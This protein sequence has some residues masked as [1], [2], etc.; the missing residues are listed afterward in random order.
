MLRFTFVVAAARY[1]YPQDGPALEQSPIHR[2]ADRGVTSAL[3]AL[4][5]PPPTPNTRITHGLTPPSGM[6][7]AVGSV[8]VR[9]VV[10]VVG[11][12]GGPRS[13]VVQA[14]VAHR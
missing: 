4:H 13:G 6:I 11:R 14:S 2:A 8:L 12:D 7:C 1:Q 5:P 9:L 3:T 10:I